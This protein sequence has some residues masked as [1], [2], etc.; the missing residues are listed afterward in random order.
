MSDS[1]SESSEPAPTAAKR[2]CKWGKK[3]AKIGTNNNGGR[4]LSTEYQHTTVKGKDYFCNYCNASVSG[5]AE[6][7]RNHLSKCSK[8]LKMK[9]DLAKAMD[10]DDTN[11]DDR[12]DSD[13]NILT[14]TDKIANHQ[15]EK[16]LRLQSANASTRSQSPN[17]SNRE[18][19]IPS[20]V[21]PA[22]PVFKQS[23]FNIVSTKKTDANTK[24]KLDLLVAKF[25]YA[26]NTAFRQV[27]S[28]TF[29]EMVYLANN[30]MP[31]WLVE[32]FEQTFNCKQ[33]VFGRKVLP[34]FVQR[35]RK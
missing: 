2:K 5:R 15:T 32:L 26:S 24:Q 10:S 11:D 23:F 14:L 4:K 7:I 21:P 3:G 29:R 6:R 9:S 31:G 20:S 8:Y 28:K 17:Q 16:R 12:D 1:E 30:L 13:E 33:R 35:S 22:A 19:S 18:S 25:F 34:T 27:D